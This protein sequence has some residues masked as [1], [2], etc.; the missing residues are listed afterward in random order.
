MYWKSIG[1]TNYYFTLKYE[2][3]LYILEDDL[4]ERKFLIRKI[5]WVFVDWI[6]L[7]RYELILNEKM[8]F[9]TG[10]Q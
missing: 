8:M 6:C 2:L 3:L 9:S 5:K 10:N 1:E 7:I 4:V